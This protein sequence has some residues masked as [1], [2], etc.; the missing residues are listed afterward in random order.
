M[1]SDDA[2][3]CPICA[4]DVSFTPAATCRRALTLACCS[5][6]IC[7]SCEYQHIMSV[8]E[9]GVSGQGRSHLKCPLGCGE[10]IPEKVVRATIQRQHPVF[11]LTPLFFSGLAALL[12]LTGFFARQDPFA[13]C[14]Y[15]RIWYWWKYSQKARSD[16]ER[17][18]Q[19]SLTVA[20]RNK[21]IMHCPAPDCGYS[22]Y[23]NELYRKHKQQ[24]ERKKSYLFYKPPKAEKNAGN[25]QWVEP[26][27]VNLGHS[28]SNFLETDQRD[29]RRIVCAKC[30]T[31]FCGL[32]RNP[33]ELSKKKSHQGMACAKYGRMLPQ[34]TDFTFVAQ[35]TDAR[36]CPSCSMRTNR[37]EGCNHMTCP[38][39]Q[40]WCY[41][42]ECSWN[43]RHYS[44]VDNRSTN[45]AEAG[46]CIVS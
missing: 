43:P 9:E 8:F 44:C 1:T 27:Y 10:E 11:F 4:E 23:T 6:L 42:C 13:T 7:Q 39:G 30:L 29:G 35:L 20:M 2:L 17:Y 5:Q 16:I 26:E 28:H 38:C 45:R 33:W 31:I 37:T 41:V 12:Q 19:W 22:W 14:R 46:A 15:Y 24:H 36:T 40:E 18:S 3:L 21:P 32:C 25:F 34:D